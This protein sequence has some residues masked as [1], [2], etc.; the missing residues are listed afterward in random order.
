MSEVLTST[1]TAEPEGLLNREAAARWLGLHP[2]TLDRLRDGGKVR[3][4]RIGRRSLYRREALEAFA[5][6]QES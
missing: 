1:G 4:V 2:R 6:A 5:R 3:T